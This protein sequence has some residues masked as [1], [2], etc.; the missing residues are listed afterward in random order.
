MKILDKLFRKSIPDPATPPIYRGKN[1]VV[2]SNR[3]VEASYRLG[4]NEQKFLL[5]MITKIQPNQTAHNEWWIEPLETCDELG[6][7]RQGIGRYLIRDIVRAL[8]TKLVSFY[9]YDDNQELRRWETTWFS[10]ADYPTDYDDKGG[11]LRVRFDDK[12]KPHLLEL[13][14]NFTKYN[15]TTALKFRSKYSIRIYELL[16]EYEYKGNRN[17]EYYRL[18][19]MLG[20]DGHNQDGTTKHLRF[21][22]YNDFKKYALL[23]AEKELK[24]AADICFTFDEIKEGR[25]VTEIRF[26]IQ[27]NEP[28]VLFHDTEDTPSIVKELIEAG[29]TSEQASKIWQRQFNYLNKAVRDELKESEITFVQYLR[30]KIYY[31]QVK[32]KDDKV[33]NPTAYLIQAIKQNY[34]TSAEMKIQQDTEIKMINTKYRKLIT[35]LNKKTKD[36]DNKKDKAYK[37]ITDDFIEFNPKLLEQLDI[38]I[39]RKK[40]PVLDMPK[41]RKMKPIE[42]YKTSKIYQ[43][44]LFEL[45]E[46]LYSDKFSKVKNEYD[47]RVTAIEKQKKEIQKR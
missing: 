30:E 24:T 40:Y 8:Q 15:L 6:L 32:M 44:I 35:A 47:K 43:V 39:D 3:L 18:R 17:I 12:L 19:L 41:Y 1:M 22:Q 28:D 9:D 10:A 25:K 42:L 31:L 21:K 11:K 13:R 45:L 4:L 46:K 26:N 29:L 2:K 16:K 36:E 20:L 38:Q 37:K 5:L 27:K 7:D 23:V 33:D 34:D 14:K